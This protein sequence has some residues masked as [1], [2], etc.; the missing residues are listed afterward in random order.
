MI[1]FEERVKRIKTLM[2]VMNLTSLKLIRKSLETSAPK[3]EAKDSG[4]RAAAAE[5]KK[6]CKGLA[7]TH[8]K[9]R[10]QKK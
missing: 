9:H 7:G 3:E 10:P 1:V 5:R 4:C 6:N 8:C 2:I